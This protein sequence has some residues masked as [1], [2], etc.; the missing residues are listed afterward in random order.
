MGGCRHPELLVKIDTKH[1]IVGQS[2]KITCMLQLA[3][4]IDTH[5]IWLETLR[6]TTNRLILDSDRAPGGLHRCE[7][8]QKRVLLPKPGMN[9]TMITLISETDGAPTRFTQACKTDT[10]HNIAG[11]IYE[12]KHKFV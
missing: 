3:C 7:K 2:M 12:E 4:K 9:N 8:Q 11:Q 10:K 1:N 5:I 6:K